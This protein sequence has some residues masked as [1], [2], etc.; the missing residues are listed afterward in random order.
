MNEASDISGYPYV[1]A[2]GTFDPE[3]LNRMLSTRFDLDVITPVLRILRPAS[4][5]RVF[6]FEMNRLRFMPEPNIHDGV[7]DGHSYRIDK[8]GK[9]ISFVLLLSSFYFYNGPKSLVFPEMSDPDF[10]D[11]LFMELSANGIPGFA[12]K[13]PEP[14]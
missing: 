10:R 4:G 11:R 5:G 9:E 14:V 8:K 3:H 2:Y 12:A 7:F 13:I 1:F 6:M